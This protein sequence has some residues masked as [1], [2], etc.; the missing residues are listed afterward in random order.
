VVVAEGWGEAGPCSL[1]MQEGLERAEAG[2]AE[3]AGL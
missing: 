2:E 3:R 1:D